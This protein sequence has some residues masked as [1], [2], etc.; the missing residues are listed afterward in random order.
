MKM[1]WSLDQIYDL[2]KIDQWFLAEMKQLGRFRIATDGGRSAP[3]FCGRRSSGAIAT[4]RSPRPCDRRRA[5]IRQMRKEA[6]IEPVYKL[7]DTCAAEFEASTPYYYSTYETP[8]TVNGKTGHRKTKSASPTSPK[9]SS[10]AADPTGS[11]RGLSLIIAASRRRLRCGS[12]GW[13]RS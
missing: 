13:N 12:W 3:A 6:G 11:G 5:A 4:S 2:T 7:V 1:G 10:S 8:F 9:S